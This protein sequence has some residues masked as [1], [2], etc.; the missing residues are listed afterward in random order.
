MHFGLKKVYTFLYP[1]FTMADNCIFCRI[2]SG[3]IPSYK[4]YED[5]EFLAFL[6]I[7]QF[8]PGHTLVI[9]KQHYR[10]VWDVENIAG[11]Y[12]VVQKIAAHYSALGYKF[13]D[14]LVMGRDVP[15]AHVHL[16]P[17]NDNYQPW[18]EATA[19]IESASRPETKLTPENG[20]L[21]VNKLKLT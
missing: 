8:T 13:I 17:H 6:D 3:E 14:S 2:I 18:K 9:P 15:H 16:I 20:N 10:F 21:L 19:A 5:S 7:S 11:Y 4:V 12:Q 1:F